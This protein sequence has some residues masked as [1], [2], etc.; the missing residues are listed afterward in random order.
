MT[1]KSW[2]IVAER[3]IN[4]CI[5]IVVKR[6]G[7]EVSRSARRTEFYLQY[8]SVLKLYVYIY[9][10]EYIERY[11]ETLQECVHQ[12]ERCKTHRAPFQYLH[13]SLSLSLPF[14]VYDV[15]VNDLSTS[16]APATFAKHLEILLRWSLFFF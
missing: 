8:I 9:I 5:R 14:S 7:L 15:V 12:I 1:K 4:V 2:G 6:Y 3:P 11:I 10:F 16:N 13:R